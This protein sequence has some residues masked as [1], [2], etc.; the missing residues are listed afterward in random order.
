MFWGE[1]EPFVTIRSRGAQSFS[2]Q[3]VD[4][5]GSTA[6]EDVSAAFEGLASRCHRYA[7]AEISEIFGIYGVGFQLVGPA[8]GASRPR[9]PVS[10]SNAFVRNYSRYRILVPARSMI[11]LNCMES[12]SRPAP[13]LKRQPRSLHS[14]RNIR[15]PSRN[16]ETLLP[17]ISVQSTGNSE[18]F[19]PDLSRC[20]SK[21]ISNPKRD[22]VNC[23][24]TAK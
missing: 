18:I 13:T 10:N 16:N 6:Q 22:S 11:C 8:T 1:H 4:W 3:T 15:N 14:D 19:A 9:S 23:E 21:S 2:V 17:G 24:R 12:P 7:V 20:T 5:R